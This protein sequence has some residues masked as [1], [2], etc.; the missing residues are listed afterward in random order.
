M[1][2]KCKTCNGTGWLP[3]IYPDL[4][5][6][7]PRYEVSCPDCQDKG[8]C[9]NCGQMMVPLFGFD[10]LGCFPQEVSTTCPACKFVL[11]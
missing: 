9:P 2:G 8:I 4:P 1:T 11:E 7:I 6:E 10:L 3:P 5:K